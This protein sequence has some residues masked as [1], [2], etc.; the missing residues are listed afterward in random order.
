MTKQLAIVAI[1]A[2]LFAVLACSSIGDKITGGDKLTKTEDLWP[3]VPKMDGMAPSELELPF[4]VK[5]LFR[6]VLN[7]LWRFD[8]SGGDKT[9]ASGDWAAYRTDSTPSDVQNFYSNDRMTSAGWESSKQ[10][11]CIDGNKNGVDGVI[12]VFKKSEGTNDIG[13]A[14]IAMPEEK[15][16]T[17]IF[18]IRVQSPKPENANKK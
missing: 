5:V 10:S 8:K 17:N 14:V 3:D 18:F 12:C 7:N 2:I 4:A 13:L 1:V 11:T 15:K 9:P 6:T 16:G